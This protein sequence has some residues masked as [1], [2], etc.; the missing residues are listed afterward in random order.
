MTPAR[1]VRFSL[2]QPVLRA[3]VACAALATCLPGSPAHAAGSGGATI[4][5]TPQAQ[6]SAIVVRKIT[7]VRGCVSIT[8]AQPGAT[9]RFQGP[10]LTHGKR[11]VYLGAAGAQDDVLAKLTM[12]KQGSDRMVTALV[13]KRAATGPVAIEVAEGARSAASAA[14]V[15]LPAPVVPI[16]AIAGNGPFFPI[17]GK[18]KFRTRG[19]WWGP[20]P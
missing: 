18:Y 19:V 16:A 8:T 5:L 14:S 7:C 6:A 15:V 10:L 2:L 11:V 17:R 4:I 1:S 12:K 3:L 9:L 13:P 20:R